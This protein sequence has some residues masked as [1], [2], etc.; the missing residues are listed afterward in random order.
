MDESVPEEDGV[1]GAF[2][3]LRLNSA[4]GPSVMRAEHLRAC[5][6]EANWEEFLDPSQLELIFGLTQEYLLE[7]HLTEE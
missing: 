4:G 5:M 2:H 7:G 1:S 6:W 3:H